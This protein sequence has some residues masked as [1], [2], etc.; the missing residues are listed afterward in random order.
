MQIG[1]LLFTEL[2]R[3]T[4]ATSTYYLWFC[5]FRSYAFLCSHSC[6]TSSAA[7]TRA[8]PFLLAAGTTGKY[9]NFT[10]P[11]RSQESRAALFVHPYKRQTCRRYQT[12]RPRP[13]RDGMR[14]ITKSTLKR[15]RERDLTVSNQQRNERLQLQHHFV[16]DLPI[17][18]HMRHSQNHQSNTFQRYLLVTQT[19]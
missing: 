4:T 10:R 14:W 5:T 12:Y 19:Y 11:P 2:L 15:E 13:R 6:A 7:F 8:N 1:H 17:Q 3:T 18:S 9:N 16:H